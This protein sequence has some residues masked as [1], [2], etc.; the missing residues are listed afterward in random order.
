LPDTERERSVAPAAWSVRRR[1]VMASLALH[2]GVLA[3]ILLLW[4]PMKAPEVAIPVITVIVEGPGSAG[5]SA[6][7]GA[8][9][10][11]QSEA[12]AVAATE[13]PPE[14]IPQPVPTITPP[15]PEPAPI[16][17]P[18]VAAVAPPPPPPVPSHKPAPTAPAPAQAA[19]PAPPAVAAAVG[20]A[21]GTGVSTA[22]QGQGVA[23][24]GQGVIGDGPREGPGDQYL[25][26]LRRWLA[27][28]KKYPK[29][30]IERKQEGEVVVGFTLARDG[31]VLK[32]WIE[33]SS[34]IAVIDDSALAMMR[35]ASPVPP[36]PQHYKG[37][38]LKL[39]MPVNYSIGFFD[40]LF[41]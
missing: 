37:N 6:G 13:A 4:H 22:G 16:V 1:G 10:E 38:E 8:P 30:A 26:E 3:A 25:D 34:G 41:R 23:G 36:V 32:A 28:Y 35:A 29:E 39:A 12:P 27:K 33:H 11:A 5:G 40:K 20:P 9:A 2:L 15:V 7:G 14:P 31:T 18:R 19:S 24:E 21:V 17:V